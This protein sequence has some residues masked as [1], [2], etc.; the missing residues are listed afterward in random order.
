VHRPRTPE[1]VS[2]AAVQA[3]YAVYL[4][5]L[6]MNVNTTAN[7]T[8][9]MPKPKARAPAEEHVVRRHRDFRPAIDANTSTTPQPE[10]RPSRP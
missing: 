3:R 1:G 2:E 5:F 4:P 6:G 9:F 8:A 7:R 10:P